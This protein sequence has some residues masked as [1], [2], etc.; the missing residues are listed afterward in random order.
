MLTDVSPD[1]ITALVPSYSIG[2]VGRLGP[3]GLGFFTMDSSI[4][5]AVIECF[6]A[7]YVF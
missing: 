3:V 4:C 7:M 2:Y 6:P 1:S 5:V